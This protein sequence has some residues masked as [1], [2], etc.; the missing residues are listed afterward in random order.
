MLIV[1]MKTAMEISNQLH[2][3]PGRGNYLRTTESFLSRILSDLRSRV[4]AER[5]T[6]AKQMKP[7]RHRVP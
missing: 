6:R 2:C 4:E 1:H 3:A 5:L 7:A